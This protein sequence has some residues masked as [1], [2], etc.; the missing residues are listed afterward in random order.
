[1]FVLLFLHILLMFTAV[2]VASGASVL[3]LMGARRGDRS[4]VAAITSL[5]IPQMAPILYISGG[6]LGLLTGLAFGYNLLAPWLIIAYVGFA[7]FAAFGILYTGPV[8]MRTHAVAADPQASGEV[9]A[10]AM[11][12]FRTDAVV[13]MAGIAILVADMVFKPFS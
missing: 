10:T 4:M 11:S 7:L 1:M 8:F 6:V 13:S 2:A 3:V 9:F 5:P 12:R